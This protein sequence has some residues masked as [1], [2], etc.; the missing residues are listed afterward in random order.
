MKQR[1]IAADSSAD[2]AEF[3]GASKGGGYTLT[4]AVQG[5]QTYS[6]TQLLA[7]VKR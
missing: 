1:A 5:A 2:W 7:N 6:G 4:N 3:L